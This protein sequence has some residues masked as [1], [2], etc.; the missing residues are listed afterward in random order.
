LYEAADID[1]ANRWKQTLS[2]TIPS[3]MPTIVILLLLKIGDF[4]DFGFERVWVFLNP[5]TFENGEILDTYIYRAG[6]LQ[7]EYSFTTAVG[8]FKSVIGLIM[9]VGANK[10][11]KK[12]TGESLY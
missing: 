11:S 8:M 12:T 3:I 2:I 5:L 10:L 6:L 4:L 9:L 1:G 7:Q